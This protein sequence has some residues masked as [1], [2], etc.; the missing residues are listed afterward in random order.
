MFWPNFDGRQTWYDIFEI[1][2]PNTNFIQI[3]NNGV[4][5]RLSETQNQMLLT[6]ND[7]K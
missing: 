3:W 7:F 5:Y 4:F 2:Y 1:F 6:T